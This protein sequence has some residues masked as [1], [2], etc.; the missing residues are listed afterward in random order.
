VDNKFQKLICIDSANS[1]LIK[2]D[3]EYYGIELPHVYHIYSTEKDKK[4]NFQKIGVYAKYRFFNK[5][6]WRDEQIGT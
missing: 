2:N 5:A 1:L 3:V 4:G 6:K